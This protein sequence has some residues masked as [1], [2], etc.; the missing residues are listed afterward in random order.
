[1]SRNHVLVFA[2]SAMVSSF[3]YGGISNGVIS[4][5][6]GQIVITKDELPEGKSDK[7]SVM[8]IHAVELKELSGTK[9][10]DITAWHF[11]Y[12]AFL[13]AKGETDLK[14][15]FIVDDKDRHYSADKAI[16][17]VDPKSSVLSGD[18]SIDEDE[19]LAKGKTYIVELVTP[20]DV[21]VAKTSVL[22]D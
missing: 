2:V 19:G 4:N 18:I 3:A 22:F 1:M 9:A 16:Q 14:M 6:H 10:A 13:T 20:K 8:K 21:V 17:G 15:E 7:D 5:F 11:H 12:T